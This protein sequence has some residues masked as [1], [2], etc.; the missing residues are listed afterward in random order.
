MFCPEDGAEIPMSHS[1]IVFAFYP[2]CP[3]CGTSWQYNGEDG[4]YGQGKQEDTLDD[5]SDGTE[6]N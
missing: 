4:T 5:F 6:N 1:D 3:D 2:P